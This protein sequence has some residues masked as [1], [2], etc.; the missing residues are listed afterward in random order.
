M[1]RSMTG[2]GR[3]DAAAEDSGYL[4]ELRSTNHRF[5]EVVCRLPRELV[6]LEARVK[7][8]VKERL[9]RGR[10]EVFVGRTGAAQQG[11]LVIDT[12]G[13]RGALAALRVAQGVLQVAGEVGLDQLLTFRELFSFQSPPVDEQAAW[14]EMAAALHAALERWDTSRRREGEAL[15]VDVR[16][17]LATLSELLQGVEVDSAGVAVE[18]AQRLRGRL[19]ELLAGSGVDPARFEQE[20]GLLATRADITEEIVRLRSH[21]Q[22]FAAALDEGDAPGR[23]LD[24]LLQEMVRE[25]NTIGSKTTQVAVTN[26]VVR[27]KEIVEQIREQ[28]QNIE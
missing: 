4:V 10:V 23:R 16:Q 2:F 17:R 11:N 12:A 3:S 8:A 20:V 28:V 22:Q 6:G 1:I 5:A 25:V 7:Q 15:A 14:D 19:A 26:R 13:L 9:Q 27:L 18:I 21:L 24:F